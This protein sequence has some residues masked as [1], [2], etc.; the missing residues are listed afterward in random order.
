ME[1]VVK[2][3]NHF[4]EPSGLREIS[5]AKQKPCKRPALVLCF[6]HSFAMNT[7]KASEYIHLNFY[8]VCDAYEIYAV[9]K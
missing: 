6:R 4:L 3:K 5:Y 2:D 7:V 8:V 9:Y 1:Q